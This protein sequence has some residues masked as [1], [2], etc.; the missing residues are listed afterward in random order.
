MY[1][2]LGGVLTMVIK[3]LPWFYQQNQV[4][5]A[6]ILPIALALSLTAV[7]RKD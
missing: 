1:V 4:D 5:L 2:F 7:Y 6:L 3:L